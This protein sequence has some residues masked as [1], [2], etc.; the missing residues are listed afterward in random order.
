VRARASR[1]LLAPVDD[2]WSFVS[3]P[4]NLP[5]WWPGTGGVEPDRRGL[6]PG[7]RWLV[8]GEREPSIL[9]KAAATDRL[10][11]LAVERGRR[12]AFR[13]ARERLGVELLLEPVGTARTRAT[14]A[15]EGRLLVGPPR[16][17][18]R[19]AVNRL[20]ALCQTAAEA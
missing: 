3:E 19:Q 2:V 9:R 10:E 18:P 11:V 20:H 14:V 13:L 17:F 15:V 6:A 1:E 16:S 12:I 7:A 5:N 4:Y 8:T